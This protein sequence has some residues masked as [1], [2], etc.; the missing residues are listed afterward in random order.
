MFK[1]MVRIAGEF[2]TTLGIWTNNMPR[3]NAAAKK[4]KKRLPI[5]DM[6][7]ETEQEQ[8]AEQEPQQQQREV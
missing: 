8:D 2:Q 1:L 7:E 5:A 6:E 4:G 3:R